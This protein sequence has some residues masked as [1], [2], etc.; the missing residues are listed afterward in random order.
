MFLA[1]VA[2]LFGRRSKVVDTIELAGL[3]AAAEQTAPAVE[4]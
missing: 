3:V 2:E 1:I 4:D